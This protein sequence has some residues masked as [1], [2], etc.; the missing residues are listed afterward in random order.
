[1]RTSILSDSDLIKVVQN[2]QRY[3]MTLALMAGAVVTSDQ[4]PGARTPHTREKSQARPGCLARASRRHMINGGLK[5]RSEAPVRRT[6]TGLL[7]VDC[8]HVLALLP[9]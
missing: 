3:F 5:F 2:K 1:M 6:K 7:L 8:G 4:A 9:R